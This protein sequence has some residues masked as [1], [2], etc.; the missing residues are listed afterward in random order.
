ML[1]RV[2]LAVLPLEGAG[3]RHSCAARAHHLVAI[4][5]PTLVDSMLAGVVHAIRC[6]ERAWARL[7]RPASPGLRHS[8]VFRPALIDS[9]LTRSAIANRVVECSWADFSRA[10]APADHLSAVLRPALIDGMLAFVSSPVRR[11][12]RSWT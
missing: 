3:A 2:H 9:I 4:L 10:T 5:R 7:V 8:A 11:L 1:A 12:E 6:L